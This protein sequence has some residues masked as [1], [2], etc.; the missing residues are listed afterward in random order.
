MVRAI[1]TKKKITVSAKSRKK[2]ILLIEDDSF[3]SGMYIAKLTIENFEVLLASDGQ[4]GIELAKKSKPDL[5]LLDLLLPKV[6]GYTVLKTIKKNRAL[7]T[8]PVILLTN[9]TQK[10]NI[11][12]AMKYQI[13]DYL[14]KA[15]FMPSEV[16][17][18]VK[19]ILRQR[20]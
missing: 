16:I 13:E 18:K 4:E 2:R 7:A 14:I 5:I 15:H 19:R 6:D 10:E 20:R 9:L 1:K 11:E 8:I 3:L 12:K 17:E